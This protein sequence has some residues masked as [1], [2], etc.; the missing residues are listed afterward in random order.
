MLFLL[1]IISLSLKISSFRKTLS[2]LTRVS[3]IKKIKLQSKADIENR[4]ADILIAFKSSLNHIPFKGNCLSQS[5][6]L[7]WILRGHGINTDLKIGT[8]KENEVFKAHAWVELNGTPL[9]DIIS[10]KEEF[11]MFKQNFQS[12]D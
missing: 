10:V 6:C 8:S 7:W 3:S 4:L 11:N 5:L 12:F 1:P 2:L 9:N